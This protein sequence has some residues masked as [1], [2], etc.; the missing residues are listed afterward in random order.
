MRGE[1]TVE[2]V[3]EV[4]LNPEEHQAYKWV[5]NRGEVEELKVPLGLKPVMMDL[6]DALNHTASS[7]QE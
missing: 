4:R 1:T 6:L 7:G 2:D 3:V 5:G